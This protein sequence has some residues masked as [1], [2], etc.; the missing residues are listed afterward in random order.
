MGERRKPG[1]LSCGAMV[2]SIAV[3]SSGDMLGLYIEVQYAKSPERQ[4]SI[5]AA[6]SSVQ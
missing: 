3:L 6:T 4:V 5:H 1:K 2:S